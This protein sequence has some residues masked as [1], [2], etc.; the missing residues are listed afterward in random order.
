MKLLGVFVTM[1]RMVGKHFE[2]G[3]QNLKKAA[4]S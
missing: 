3:L 4:E 1:D 2:S